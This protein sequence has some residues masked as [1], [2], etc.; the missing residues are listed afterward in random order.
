M[1]ITSQCDGGG[2][3]DVERRLQIGLV[4]TREHPFGVGGFELRVEVDLAVDGVDEAVQALTGVGVA[5]HRVDDEHVAL[6]QAGQ[7]DA[8][9]LVVAGDVQ[10]DPVE[11]GAVD[12]VGGD[13]DIGVGAGECLELDGR[14]GAEGLFAGRA[15][16]VGQ[17][18]VDAVAVDGDERSSFDGLVAGQIGKYHTSNLMAALAAGGPEAFGYCPGMRG[19][20]AS[21]DKP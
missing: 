13:V 18:E 1:E 3:G 19:S 5:A 16:A 8:G 2:D 6:L 11:G 17:V 20:P 14:H 9:G 7:G 21:P 10:L 12:G 4:E 15:G